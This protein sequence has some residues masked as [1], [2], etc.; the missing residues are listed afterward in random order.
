MINLYFKKGHMFV[1]CQE[2]KNAVMSS[3]ILDLFPVPF[4]ISRVM[5]SI[6]V[7]SPSEELV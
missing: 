3:L 7:T 4:K 1:F 6:F 5:S 2:I